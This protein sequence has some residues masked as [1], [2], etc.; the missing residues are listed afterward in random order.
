MSKIKFEDVMALA[1][2]GKHEEKYAKMS[3]EEKKS[4]IMRSLGME[5]K[6]NEV[7]STINNT[8]W[9][10]AYGM[11]NDIK[12]LTPQ[13][14]K[15]LSQFQGGF[16]GNNLPVSYPIPYDI[17]DYY[18]QGKSEWED[19]T[20]PAF[21][22]KTQ[23][24]NKNTLALTPLILEFGISDKM[25]SH[26]TDKQLY[27]KVLQKL[28]KSAARTIESMIING[29]STAG[30]TGN[31]NSD[32]QAPATTFAAD[33]GTAYHATLLDHGIRENSI[34]NSNTYNV[35]AFDSDDMLATVRKLAERYQE[36]FDD[37][38][39]LTNPSTGVVMMTDDGFKLASS[40]NK[41]AAIDTGVIA[42]PWG[43]DMVSSPLVPKAEAD[44]KVSKTPGNNTLGQFAVVYKPAVRWGFGKDI[45]VE[46]V[47]VAG[48]GFHMIV[49]AEAGFTILDLTNTCA[50]GMNVTIA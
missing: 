28:L 38:L 3:D 14:G 27:E 18:M 34:T 20:K 31:V 19:E 36:E 17:T 1:G 48:Y 46:V 43:I 40:T 47:R 23:T 11:V 44:G 50:L 30:A 21:N 39:F 6:A 12:D 26:S 22:I 41:G 49:T 10:D 24:D 33:G 9:Y 42:K 35:G 16:E 2:E 45:Q 15:V 8:N 13:F 29:D 37:I 7:L 32:D 25:I 5:T 4:S